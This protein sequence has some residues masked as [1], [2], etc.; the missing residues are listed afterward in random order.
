MFLFSVPLFHT[1]V[2]FFHL[3]THHYPLSSISKGL[4]GLGLKRGVLSRTVTMSSPCPF[5]S[6]LFPPT[7]PPF[8]HR[9]CRYCAAATLPAQAPPF[10]HHRRLSHGAAVC[11][12][13][14]FL[15][16]RRFLARSDVFYSWKMV[17]RLGTPL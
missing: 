3:C 6:D 9:C 11:G 16:L 15:A 13:I 7:P 10:P 5:L 17:R 14:P 8:L 12:D 1:S 4:R 2:F